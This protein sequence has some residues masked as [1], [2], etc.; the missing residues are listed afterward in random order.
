ML[1]R[2]DADETALQELS[3]CLKPLIS[4]LGLG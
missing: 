1:W 2:E 3:A 4:G